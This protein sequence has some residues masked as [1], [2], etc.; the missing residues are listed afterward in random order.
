[1][2]ASEKAMLARMFRDGRAAQAERV[3]NLGQLVGHQ[4]DVGGLERGIGAGDA[5]RDA[6]VG[7]R[8]RRRVV[9]AVAHHRQRAVA[10]AELFDCRELVFRQQRRRGSRRCRRS[11]RA[12]APRARD[13]RSAARRARRRAPQQLHAC[14]A[15]RLARLVGHA[16]DAERPAPSTATITV[17]RPRAA[18]VSSARVDVRAGHSR[19]SS[20]SRWLPTTTARA[21]D[22]ALR[23][24]P[25]QRLERA[26]PATARAPSAWARSTI[27]RPIG[28]S[29]RDSSEAASARISAAARR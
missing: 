22:V 10:R 6:D 11:R 15:A 12:P 26:R 2:S 9:D 24:E 21:A 19:R 7:G 5:H 27:A 20:N 29:E 23:A 4:R 3:G 25:G 8:Q 28:C 16:D 13:R 18:S 17:L 1:M 14:R